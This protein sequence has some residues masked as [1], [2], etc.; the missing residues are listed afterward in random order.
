MNRLKQS[1]WDTLPPQC[2]WS[3]RH[4]NK[5]TGRCCVQN[6]RSFYCRVSKQILNRPCLLTIPNNMNNV[7]MFKHKI[8]ES[9]W[10]IQENIS[11]SFPN[12]FLHQPK[13]LK[14]DVGFLALLTDICVLGWYRMCYEHACNIRHKCHTNVIVSLYISY[15]VTVLLKIVS[16]LS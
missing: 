14:S 13:T 6:R 10:N 2:H 3:W 1:D 11:W 8:R 4:G 7:Y 12:L 16:N 5:G 15:Q 9:L